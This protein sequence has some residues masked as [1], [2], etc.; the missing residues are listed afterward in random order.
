M[1]NDEV[2]RIPSIVIK[3]FIFLY[4]SFEGEQ[5]KKESQKSMNNPH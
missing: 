1:N 4:C 2:E 5:N 3:Y